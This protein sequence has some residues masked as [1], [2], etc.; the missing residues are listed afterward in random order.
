MNMYM[1]MF[2]HSLIFIW[3]IVNESHCTILDIFPMECTYLFVFNIFYMLTKYILHIFVYTLFNGIWY[4]LY[5]FE[6]IYSIFSHFIFISRKLILMIKNECYVH[7]KYTKR[8]K[9]QHK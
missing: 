5:M 7:T 8:K 4:I 2:F 3:Y 9:K 1:L 6:N